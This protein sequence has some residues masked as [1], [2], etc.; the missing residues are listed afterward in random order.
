MRICFVNTLYSM[1][2]ERGG[3]GAHIRDLS[4]ALRRRGHDVTILTSG[5]DNRNDDGVEVLGLGNVPKFSRPRQALN[6]LLLLRRVRYM[7]RMS[8]HVWR[9]S[10]DVVEAAES[11]FEH[12]LL[13]FFRDCALVTK[14]HGTFRDLYGWRPLVPL[15]EGIEKAV[16]VRC[17]GVYA[18][19]E[20]YARRVAASYG[21]SPRTIR[22][23]PCGI[24]MD[25]IRKTGGASSASPAS[26]GRRLVLLSGGTAPERKGLK[27]YCAAAEKLRHERI[28]FVLTCTDRTRLD[29]FRV[30]DNVAVVERLDRPQ[31]YDWLSRADVVVFPSVFESF[32]IAVHEAM[33]LGRPLVVSQ[34]IPLEGVSQ[35]YPRSRMLAR[36]DADSLAA[37]IR[38]TLDEAAPE[39][40][41]ALTERLREHYDIDRVADV[42]ET[43]YREA[44]TRFRSRGSRL[45]L[46]P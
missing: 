15:F 37:A 11:G 41:P 21:I 27:L 14:L 1:E 7:L 8:L 43:F 34:A 44:L 9:G 3:L 33:L 19:T 35:E 32:S 17:D 22:I 12:L 45:V 40:E 26:S 24:D 5:S 18:S 39:L 30:P 29:G 23:I 38:A 31:F 13:A 28:D 4:S 16:V 36:N 10:Y 6:P 46:F 2:E 25:S 42:T 20:I